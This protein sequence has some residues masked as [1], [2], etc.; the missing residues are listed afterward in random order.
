MNSWAVIKP[1][2]II[3]PND[4]DIGS[5]GA[6]DAI[7]IDSGGIVTFKDDIKI[8]DGGTI[9]TATTDDAMTVASNGIVTFK[10][11]ILVKNDGT[12]GSAGAA[13]AITIDSSGN[14]TLV[15]NLVVANAK[16]IDFSAVST[17]GS[18]SASALLDDY[19]EGSF[20]AIIGATGDNP[21][22]TYDLQA[23]R[24]VKIGRQVTCW[25]QIHVNIAYTAGSGYLVLKTLPF[26][27]SNDVAETGGSIG[28]ANGWSGDHPVTMQA[29][30]GQAYAF[31]N[32]NFE[33]DMLDGTLDLGSG[34]HVTGCISYLT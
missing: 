33:N 3:I 32:G 7:Q 2:S 29:G 5:A 12:I 15:G 4:G 23:G 30:A 6:N 10:D 25:F 16:G 21:N 24:Y 13:T 27:V 8:K 17:S 26:T 18:G 28:R 1:N 14:V 22:L 20:T 9:G 11:D 19:E 31:F 34:A